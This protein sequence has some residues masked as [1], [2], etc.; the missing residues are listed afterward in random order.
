MKNSLVIDDEHFSHASNGDGVVIRLGTHKIAAGQF[1]F[2]AQ[3]SGKK[4][5]VVVTKVEHMPFSKVTGD[6]FALNRVGYFKK[7]VGL[8]DE[9]HSH[10]MMNLTFS[11]LR[12]GSPGIRYESPVTVITYRLA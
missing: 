6:M 10:R 12:A 5:P 2:V 1:N 8:G 4:L 7:P 11:H 9:D 3:G